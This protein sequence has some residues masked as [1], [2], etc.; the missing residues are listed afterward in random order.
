MNKQK[1]K[2]NSTPMNSTTDWASLKEEHGV[3][4]FDPNL[5]HHE[6]TDPNIFNWIQNSERETVHLRF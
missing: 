2:E 6:F 4:T 5:I 3:Y 1:K